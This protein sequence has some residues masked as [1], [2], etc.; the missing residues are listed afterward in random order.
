[1]NKTRTS[2]IRCN[3]VQ[4]FFAPVITV[5]GPGIDNHYDGRGPRRQRAPDQLPNFYHDVLTFER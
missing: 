1:M 5:F 3:K 2:S 4:L